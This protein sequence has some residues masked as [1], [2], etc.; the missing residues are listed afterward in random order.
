MLQKFSFFRRL[1]ELP[2]LSDCSPEVIS[3]LK[4][5]MAEADKCPFN[6]QAN[7]DF[8]CRSKAENFCYVVC[9]IQYLAMYRSVVQFSTLQCSVMLYSSVPCSVV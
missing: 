7:G 9:A 5:R 8:Y 1:K 2:E 3:H 4:Q 6:Q